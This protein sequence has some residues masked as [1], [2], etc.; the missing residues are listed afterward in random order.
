MVFSESVNRGERVSPRVTAVIVNWNGKRELLECLDSLCRLDYPED[1]LEIV[2]VDNG[3]TDGSREAVAEAFDNVCI[4]ENN[5]N[6]GYVRAVNRGIEHA[7]GHGADY[8]WVL[9]N[10][11]LADGHSLSRMVEAGE[12]NKLAGVIGPLVCS[13][14]DPNRIDNS[15]YRIDYWTGR[16]IKLHFG[17]DIFQNQDMETA[18]VETNLGCANLIRSEVFDKVGLFA[19]VYEIYFEETDFN[20]RVGREGFQVIL[21]RGARV[22]HKHAATMNKHLLR[23]ARFLLRNLLIFQLKHASARHLVVFLPYYFLIHI[24]YF[25]LYGSL[26]AV[27]EKMKRN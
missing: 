10:D 18:S 20:V 27:R 11:I 14:E 21:A 23:R 5:R 22:I 6:I 1:C 9:N 19:P 13:F 8:V 2:V 17:E 7:V 25:F 26:Y 3:S 16:L 12:R 15:G 24:P 4:L